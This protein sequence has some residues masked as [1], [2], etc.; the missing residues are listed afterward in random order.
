MNLLRNPDLAAFG[1]ACAQGLRQALAGP[2]GPHS[3][4]AHLCSLASTGVRLRCSTQARAARDVPSR[5]L[6]AKT[7]HWPVSERCLWTTSARALPPAQPG[8][9]RPLRRLR[10]GSRT[11]LA[12]S[13]SRDL[14]GAT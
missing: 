4:L 7:G 3:V 12:S 11:A 9:D 10:C 6:R 14:T 5:L 13:R 1:A 8:D 2:Q